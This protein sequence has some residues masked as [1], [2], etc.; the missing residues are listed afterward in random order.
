MVMQ[1]IPSHRNANKW[2][3]DAFDFLPMEEASAVS[4]RKSSTFPNTYRH[5]C[6]LASPLNQ[7]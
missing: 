3:E 5:T 7:L 4:I 6:P 2:S 1:M